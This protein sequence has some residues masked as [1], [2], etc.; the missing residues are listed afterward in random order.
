[1]AAWHRDPRVGAVF[2]YTL[3]EDPAY[4]VGL[5]AAGLERAYPAYALWLAWARRDAASAS[6]PPARACG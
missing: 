5:L 6:G 1:L 4:P 2:Q 3:R